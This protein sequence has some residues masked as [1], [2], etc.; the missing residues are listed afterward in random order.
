MFV[1]PVSALNSN[2]LYLL[3]LCCNPH[4]ICVMQ[5]KL[6]LSEKY[7]NCAFAQNTTNG[8]SFYEFYKSSQQGLVQDGDESKYKCNS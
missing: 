6:T 8:I 1:Y 4:Q 5:N 2:S 7:T 3:L